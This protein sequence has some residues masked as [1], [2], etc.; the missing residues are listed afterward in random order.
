MNLVT[1]FWNRPRKTWLRKALF[2]IHLWLAVILGTFIAVVCVT[3]AIVVFR[4]E[5]NRLTTPGTAYIRAEPRR[6]PLDDVLAAVLRHRPADMLHNVSMEAGTD[7]AWNV[8]TNSPNR[9]RI[10][11]F[12][13]QYRGKVV[14][15]D[16]YGLD[17][18]PDVRT[19]FLQ[20]MWDLHANLLGGKTGR[21]I[22][23]FLALA[24]VALSL[25]GLVI[26]WPGRKLLRSG[27]T[28]LFGGSWKRQNYDLHKLAGFYCFA[29]LGLISFTGAYFSFPETYRL[30]VERLSRMAHAG[31]PD[32]CG[33][34][35]PPARTSMANRKVS[36]EDYITLAE[37][38]MPGYQAVFI[39]FP[40]KPGKAVGVKMKGH[41]DWHRI[42][43]SNLYL[44]P[45]TG[46][47][48]TRDIFAENTAGTQALKLMLPLHFGR[49]GERLGLGNVGT[50]AVMVIYVI[51]GLAAGV[52]MVTGYLMYWN[53]YLSKRVKRW[54][55]AR[56]RRG[57]N[58]G[59]NPALHT[60][61]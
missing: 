56:G 14:G 10:H 32:L 19:K 59:L 12:V 58:L 33:E 23:G 2:Q 46:E 9:H 47:V 5:M 36:Y 61:R 28:Y 35:G 38:A 39:S 51:V 55:G 18:K 42:G 31:A 24:T 26:W 25:S 16:D 44:E 54:F 52:L 53:R 11:N 43:L 21:L 29:L 8:R 45:A 3:G 60:G 49:F 50:Y 4:V 37:R 57:E 30:G 7:V 15:V 48:I 17:G 27:F 22:N 34:D 6:L 20:W 13:D 41:N 1:T 40:L